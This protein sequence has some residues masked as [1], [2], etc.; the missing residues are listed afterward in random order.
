[1]KVFE[2]YKDYLIQKFQNKMNKEF[3]SL[4]FLMKGMTKLR[5]AESEIL[6]PQ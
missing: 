2:E 6:K 1:L 4:M 5:G 3:Q